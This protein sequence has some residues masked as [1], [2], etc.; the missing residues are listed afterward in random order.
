MK[1]I[2]LEIKTLNEIDEEE[3]F[4]ARYLYLVC[5]FL[6]LGCSEEEAHENAIMTMKNGGR[7]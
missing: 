6:S 5:Y 2:M 7:L 4:R 3:L 1:H